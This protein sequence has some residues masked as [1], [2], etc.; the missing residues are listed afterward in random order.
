MAFPRGMD[1][2][3]CLN[4]TGKLSCS[5]IGKTTTNHQQGT[6]AVWDAARRKFLLVHFLF[7]SIIISVLFPL[8]YPFMASHF[9][10]YCAV[11]SD[12]PESRAPD[13]SIVIMGHV[14]RVSKFGYLSAELKDRPSSDAPSKK[15]HLPLFKA[16]EVAYCSIFFL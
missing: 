3:V 12:F 14:C 6:A 13:A 16:T 11:L 9:S 2:F 10:N 7:Q 1:T 5:H 8:A 4:G 15:H